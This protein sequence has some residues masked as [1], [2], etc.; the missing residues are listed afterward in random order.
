M[1]HQSLDEEFFAL[2]ATDLV[3]GEGGIVV[4]AVDRSEIADVETVNLREVHLG[5][6]YVEVPLEFA[7]VFHRHDGFLLSEV[8]LAEDV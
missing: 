5:I 6:F 4:G 8:V 3:G 2:L 7:G 1:L